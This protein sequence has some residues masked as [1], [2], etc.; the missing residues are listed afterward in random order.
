MHSPPR[1]K[2]TEIFSKNALCAHDFKWEMETF[3]PKFD[4]SV[5][6]AQCTALGMLTISSID[7]YVKFSADDEAELT[8]VCCALAQVSL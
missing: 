5:L 1:S 3:W 2:K 8:K 4:F 7:T 6:C